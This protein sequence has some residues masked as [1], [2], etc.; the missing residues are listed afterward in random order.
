M[1]KV[2]QS[3]GLT[4]VQGGPGRPSLP[5][6]PEMDEYRIYDTP[7]EL[8]DGLMCD[9][10]LSVERFVAEKEPDGVALRF[11]AF[12][13]EAER[14]TRYVSPDRLVKERQLSA[15]RP[16][17]DQTNFA[18][19]DASYALTMENSTSLSTREKLSYSMRTKHPDIHKI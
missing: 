4:G 11:W 10:N 7:Q 19:A 8:P 12:C 5:E 17:R 1:R 14:C 18:R 16:C 2:L 9:P 6:V 15:R 3:A 13:G